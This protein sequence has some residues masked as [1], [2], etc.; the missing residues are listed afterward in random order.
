[1]D[2]IE[3][4]TFLLYAIDDPLVTRRPYFSLPKKDNFHVAITAKGGHMGWLGPTASRF[5]YRWMDQ[6]IVNWVNQID[7]A[8]RPFPL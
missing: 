4:P 1:M 3:V 2:A 5:G 8:S 6:T 7:T